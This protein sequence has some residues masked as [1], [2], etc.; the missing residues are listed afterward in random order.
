MAHNNNVLTAPQIVLDPSAGDT[1]ASAAF[2][3]TPWSR[4]N[5]R[6]H[7]PRPA[8]PMLALAP[9]VR[10]RPAPPPPRNLV[11]SS[12][13]RSEDVWTLTIFFDS[14]AIW[15]TVPALLGTL[16]FSIK[17]ALLLVLGDDSHAGE[18]ASAGAF[19][20]T[21]DF[22]SVQALLAMLMGFGWGGLGALRGFGWSMGASIGAA[23]LGAAFA[24]TILA[25][26]MRSVR[27]LSSSGNIDLTSLEG[28][29]GEVT[30]SVPAAGKGQGEVRVVLGDRERICYAVSASVEVSS[31]SR[32]R[33]VAINS[34][35]TVTVEP[36]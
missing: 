20:S 23:V 11:S 3:G 15:F 21:A 24:T 1:A 16:L 17:L 35:N 28:K 36:V 6:A 5:E 34:D 13:F 7:A 33:V 18:D 9:V 12:R 8:D 19:G 30:V 29:T 10:A 14:Q 32:I 22:L 27:S 31:R 4:R 25:L 26:A 2:A